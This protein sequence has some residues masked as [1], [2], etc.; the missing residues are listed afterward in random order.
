MTVLSFLLISLVSRADANPSVIASAIDSRLAVAQSVQKG[1][2]Q[3]INT[4]PIRL[5]YGMSNDRKMWSANA[6]D[7]RVSL[8]ST[9]SKWLRLNN[10]GRTTDYQLESGRR[11]VLR[12]DS[13]TKDIV[14]FQVAS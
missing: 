11:Y 9:F 6:I 10:R 12:Q 8:M 3:L 14:L 7:G 13:T 1:Y 2:V 4:E 5:F